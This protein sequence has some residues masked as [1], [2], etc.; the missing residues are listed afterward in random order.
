MKNLEALPVSEI[1]QISLFQGL[2]DHELDRLLQVAHPLKVLAGEFFFFQ[3]D[4][5]ERMFVLLEGRIKLSQ[6]GP[7]G[8]QALIRINKPVSLFALVALTNI[9]GYPVTAQAAI[10]CQVIYWT[11][12][13]L[14]DFVI[15]IPKMALNAMRI[16]AEQLNEIQE[17]FRQVTTERVELRLAHTLIRLAAQSG[18]KVAEGVLIDLPITRQDL[19]EMCGTTRYSASRL[20]SQWEE[21]GLVIASRERVILRSLDEL[22]KIVEET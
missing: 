14:I 18:K 8:Q 16:M 21:Q 1:K 4:P 13:E 19:A 20:L 9:A 15:Q 7:D 22:A 10:D 3:E 11:R 17:R 5:A 2:T 6:L 12:T